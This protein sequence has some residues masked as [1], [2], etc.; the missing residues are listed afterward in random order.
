M[1]EQVKRQRVME[2][3]NA[4]RGAPIAEVDVDVEVEKQGP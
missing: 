2:E 1:D 3:L 4:T